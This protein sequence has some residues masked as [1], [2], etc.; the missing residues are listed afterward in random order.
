MAMVITP[1]TPRR[2]GYVGQ[3]RLNTWVS[4]RSARSSEVGQ[5]SVG[6]NNQDWKAQMKVF[7]VADEWRAQVK[8]FAVDADWK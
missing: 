4:F 1:R 2:C 3:G 7:P 5:I 8:V 6:A